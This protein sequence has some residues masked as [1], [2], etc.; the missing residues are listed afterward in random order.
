MGT[1]S[2]S[3]GQGFSPRRRKLAASSRPARLLRFALGLLTFVAAPGMFAFSA[4]AKPE[5]EFQ[6]ASV[7]LAIGIGQ[8]ATALVVLHNST[9]ST[10][11]DVHLSWSQKPDLDVQPPSPLTLAVLAPHADHVWTLNIKPLHG[12]PA[13]PKPAAVAGNVGPSAT[14]SSV[15][16]PPGPPETRID[17]SLD[18]LLQYKAVVGGREEA[19]AVVK[20]LPVKTQDLGDVDKVLDVQIKTALESLDSSETGSIYLVLKNNS[21]RT[22]NVTSITPVAKGEVFCPDGNTKL[23]LPNRPKSRPQEDSLPF[24]FL[25][26]V[27][28]VTLHPYQTDSKELL[29]RARDRVKAG[30]YLL[31]LEIKTQSY[32]GGV[33]L[34]RSIIVSQAVDVD[35]LGE[36]A[37]LKVAGIPAFFLLPGTLLLLTIGLCWSQEGRW[38][39]RAPDGDTFPVKYTEPEFWL[40]SVT[41]SLLIAIVPWLFAGRWYFTRYGLQDIA[42]LWFASIL[43]GI[44]A[45]AI[46]WAYRDQRAKHAAAEARQREQD[47]AART[48]SETDLPLAALEKLQLRQQRVLRRKVKLKGE[49][50]FSFVLA[51]RREDANIWVC[52][53]AQVEFD[54][55]DVEQD[56]TSFL[57][58]FN[59]ERPGDLLKVLNQPHVSTNWLPKPVAKVRSVAQDRVELWTD[60]EGSFVQPG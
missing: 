22:I 39:W 47:E 34:Q 7:N 33:P 17:E 18:F 43:A 51:G 35:V 31:V 30:K 54:D 37:I 5:L 9:S 8:Q 19:Q 24:C 49:V 60:D 6:P 1:R 56:V 41:I 55:P 29:V 15:V 10:L 38:G 59:W 23:P 12:M 11:R 4:D 45:Y 58:T 32:E 25:F 57:A 2:S 28:P 46:W 42:L 21:A 27:P 48:F 50:D 52:P 13:L 3:W 26:A 44:G 36:S 20:S 16:G 14:A 53:V 40:I